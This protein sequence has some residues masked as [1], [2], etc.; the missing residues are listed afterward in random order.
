MGCRGTHAELFW[1]P[2]LNSAKSCFISFPSRVGIIGRDRRRGGQP[3]LIALAF[4]IE[5]ERKA[6]YAQLERHQRTLDV[7]M[8]LKR[9]AETVLTAQQ[10][11]LA[12]TSF[13]VAKAHF[14]NCHRDRFNDR[15]AKAVARMFRSGPD[16]FTGGLSAENYISI[17]GTSRATATR[18]L[19]HL[20]EIGALSRTGQRRYTRYWLNL[21]DFGISA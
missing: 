4:T 6:Y 21:S 14:Y 7:T 17:T 20:A 13:I 16:G 11:T 19:Q 15:Q 9:F 18:D 2:T 3:S 8:W 1:R 12:R 10:V 5:R